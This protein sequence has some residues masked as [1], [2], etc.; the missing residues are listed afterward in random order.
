MAM[1]NVPNK[2]AS[3]LPRMYFETK[4]LGM[5]MQLENLFPASSEKAR[6]LNSNNFR[7]VNF[8]GESFSFHFTSFYGVRVSKTRVRGK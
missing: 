3:I 1:A 5:M 7:A 2:E 8:E 6:H 4:L